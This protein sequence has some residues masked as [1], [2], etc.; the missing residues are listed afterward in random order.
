MPI[1][2][3]WWFWIIIIGVI[4]IIIAYILWAIFTDLRW[5]YWFLLIL[6]IVVII[7]GIIWLIMERRSTKQIEM[8]SEL[9]QQKPSQQKPIPL[10]QFTQ[11]TTLERETYQIP[12]TTVRSRTTGIKSPVSS[13]RIS[14]PTTSSP[15]ILLPSQTIRTS[16]QATSVNMF[17]V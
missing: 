9:P 7:I 16:S 4:L 3:Q 2:E 15:P 5:W 17:N 8:S 11:Q 6:G 12:Q 10:E 14:Q 13:P 1:Y